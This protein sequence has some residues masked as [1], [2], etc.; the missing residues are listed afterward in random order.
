MSKIKTRATKPCTT[1]GNRCRENLYSCSPRPGRMNAI[2]PASKTKLTRM[3]TIHNCHSLRSMRRRWVF[4]VSIGL[5]R[6]DWRFCGLVSCMVLL[7]A[8]ALGAGIR[9]RPSAARADAPTR[10]VG[11]PC[12]LHDVGHGGWLRWIEISAS[13]VKRME[14]K[15]APIRASTVIL[16]KRSW[17]QCEPCVPERYRASHWYLSDAIGG[18]FRECERLPRAE[19]SRGKL[20]AMRDSIC[21]CHDSVTWARGGRSRGVAVLMNS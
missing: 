20:F 3:A 11:L 13:G 2:K 6:F 10:T 1:G 12:L 18:G 15:L 9:N 4:T 8:L 14:G 21:A 17:F 19:S 16:A 7:S 5:L